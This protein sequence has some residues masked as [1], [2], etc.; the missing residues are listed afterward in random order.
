M[1]PSH[2][3]LKGVDDWLSHWLKLQKKKKRPLTF[4][5]SSNPQ[6]NRVRP[7]KRPTRKGKERAPVVDSDSEGSAGDSD[8]ATGN[9]ED[10][11]DNGGMDNR[12]PQ[13]KPS[14]S[15]GITDE[16]STVPPH[17]WSAI[18][19]KATRRLFLQSLSDDKS[20]RL[21]M[22]L[23]LVAKVCANCVLY[24]RDT[25]IDSMI[26]WPV[27]WNPRTRVGKLEIAESLPSR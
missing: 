23:L 24:S 7:R 9:I 25:F 14:G 8:N 6:S 17:P 13:P 12:T 1:E 3:K 18:R 11:S 10:G 26:G 19:S 21:L 16:A 27:Y 15:G 22:K 5:D 4:T 20:Y 2:M